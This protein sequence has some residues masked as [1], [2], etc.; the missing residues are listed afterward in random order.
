[1][2]GSKHNPEENTNDSGELDPGQFLR[3]IHND[4]RFWLGVLF[5]SV[6]LAA[7]TGTLELM[8]IQHN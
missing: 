3:R 6:A 2:T 5:L 1:V 4:W 7:H 8:F